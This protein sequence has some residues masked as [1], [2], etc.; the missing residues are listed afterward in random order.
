MPTAATIAT[1]PPTSS[2]STPKPPP[3]GSGEFIG[4]GPLFLRTPDF[5]VPMRLDAVYL[6]ADHLSTSKFGMPLVV[7][8]RKQFRTAQ[9]ET[10]ESYQIPP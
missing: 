6:P 2:P 8:W 9:T 1:S 4:R 5:T 3:F 10:S 7:K